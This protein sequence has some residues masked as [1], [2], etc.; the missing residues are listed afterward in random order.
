MVLTQYRRPPHVFHFFLDKKS[1]APAC[2][3]FFIFWWQTGKVKTVE[4]LAKNLPY[5]L[6]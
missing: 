1:G 6:K 3:L 5:W 2:R 4:K